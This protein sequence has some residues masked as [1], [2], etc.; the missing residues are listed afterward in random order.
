M[1]DDARAPDTATDDSVGTRFRATMRRFPA[2]VTVITAR[3]DSTDHGMTATA[4]TAVSMEPPALVVC[5]NERTLLHEML[6][7]QPSFAVNVL[8]ERHSHV[9]DAFSGHVEPE[10]RFDGPGWSRHPGPG[11]G[12]MLLDGAHASVVCRR[13]AALPYGT[14]TMFIGEVV[15]ARVDE[16]SRPLLYEDAR[17]HSS[18]PAVPDVGRHV[19]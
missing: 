18:R 15:F 1:P 7:C 19:A 10:L 8:G 3:H 9:S 5:I 16:A 4:V 12:M 6:L 2:T 11:G 13:K 14:H 17:Y